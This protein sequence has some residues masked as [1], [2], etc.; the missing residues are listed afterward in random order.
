MV[1]SGSKKFNLKTFSLAVSGGA[2]LAAVNIWNTERYWRTYAPTVGGDNLG[3]QGS[4]FHFATRGVFTNSFFEWFGY[5]L[6]TSV[7]IWVLAGKRVNLAIILLVCAFSFTA[8]T[9]L[10]DAALDVFDVG[11]LQGG[12]KM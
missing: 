4:P 7:L 12:L 3:F 11:V 1:E 2:I 9:V 6:F 10:W 5:L 8:G